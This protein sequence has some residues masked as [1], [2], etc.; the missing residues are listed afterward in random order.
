MRLGGWHLAFAAYLGVEVPMPFDDPARRVPNL[1]RLLRQ[2]HL[3]EKPE[4]WA[5]LIEEYTGVVVR[6]ERFACHDIAASRDRE[7]IDDIP[8]SR[9]I[10]ASIK[11]RGWR[12]DLGSYRVFHLGETTGM[13]T[14]RSVFGDGQPNYQD[15]WLFLSTSGVHGSYTDLDD[16]S[17]AAQRLDNGNCWNPDHDVDCE[18][19][20]PED[21][22]NHCHVRPDG[23]FCITVL[24]VKCRIVQIGYGTIWGQVRDGDIEFLRSVVDQSLDAVITSQQNNMLETGGED[25]AE[26]EWTFVDDPPDQ[27]SSDSDWYALHHGGYIKPEA[28][29]A[30]EDQI[31]A[32][33]EAEA[34]LA[35][36]FAALEEAEIRTEM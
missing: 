21:D 4:V 14:L 35:S 7:G 29:L 20:A 30:D 25:D 9:H 27:S 36:F 16:I 18:C 33:R 32:V 15:N 13:A 5:K 6:E 10:A 3:A 28:V 12:S 26:F 24:M 1:I 11:Q 19:G 22:D 17:R 8:T 23:R 31:I 34:T 2:P